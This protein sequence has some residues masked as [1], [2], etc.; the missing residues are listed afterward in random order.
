MGEQQYSALIPQLAI[1]VLDANVLS[2]PV[3]GQVVGP[4]VSRQSFEHAVVAQAP[5][6][7]RS[8]QTPAAISQSSTLELTRVGSFKVLWAALESSGL[9]ATLAGA[10]PFTV[11]A[12]T[13]QAFAALPEGTFAELLKPENKAVLVKI[14]TYHV[15]PATVAASALQPGTLKTVEGNPVQ[16][17]IDPANNQVKVN[18]AKVVL[19]NVQASNGVIHVI[20]QVILPPNI[21]ALPKGE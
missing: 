15:V 12:P 14:L 18:T 11:F 6:G 1:F 7:A 3:L 13:D 21:L 8:G 19:P 10:G 9:A 5:T 17:A 4:K 2:L 20:D 16:I